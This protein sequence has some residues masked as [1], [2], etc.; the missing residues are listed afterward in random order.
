MGLNNV[1]ADLESEDYAVQTFVIPA[2]AV[3][4][5]HR[6]G[7]VWIIANANKLANGEQHINAKAWNDSERE[8]FD[9]AYSNGERGCSGSAWKQ[10][11]SDVGQ[12]SGC[13]GNDR[14]RVGN[15]LPEPAV[16]R[17]A[18]GVPGRVD[19]LK[20]LGNAVV[21]QIPEMIGR[22]ILNDR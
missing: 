9:V 3:D 10:D 11:A 21:P 19:R 8:I 1:L 2:C 20:Q 12:P 14:S 22:A 17:V 4:A 5:K 7:R 6:R 18:H 16:G 13:S 15:W